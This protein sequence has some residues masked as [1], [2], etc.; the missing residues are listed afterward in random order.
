MERIVDRYVSKLKFG[1]EIVLTKPAKDILCGF[2][3]VCPAWSLPLGF[4][5][6]TCLTCDDLKSHTYEV[7]Y[8]Q[9]ICRVGYVSDSVRL[10]Y[11][12][13]IVQEV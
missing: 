6:L 8:L 2:Y 9:L 7:I 3:I 4:K 13:V 10:E 5:S 11:V 12:F 1:R